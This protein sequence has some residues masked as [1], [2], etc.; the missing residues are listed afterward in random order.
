M[1]KSVCLAWKWMWLKFESS[2]SPQQSSVLSENIKADCKHNVHKTIACKK[3]NKLYTKAVQ[4]II[5]NM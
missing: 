1:F 5:V 2:Y 4:S 3:Y